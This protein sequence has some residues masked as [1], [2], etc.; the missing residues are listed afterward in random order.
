MAQ[1]ISYFVMS[2]M[3]ELFSYASYGTIYLLNFLMHTSPRF[4][5]T[6]YSVWPVQDSTL[7]TGEEDEYKLKTSI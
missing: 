5:T 1:F 2:F 6:V 3:L 7:E 4:Q